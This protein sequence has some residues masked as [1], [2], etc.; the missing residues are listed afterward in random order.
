M[1]LTHLIPTPCFLGKKILLNWFTGLFGVHHKPCPSFQQNFATHVKTRWAFGV[2]LSSNYMFPSWSWLCLTERC[3]LAFGQSRQSSPFQ[4]AFT[5]KSRLWRVGWQLPV[6][7]INS[8]KQFFVH[9]SLKWPSPM[10]NGPDDVLSLSPC[11]DPVLNPVL[12]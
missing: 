1:T 7:N 9:W 3:L 10:T 11:V 12:I 4:N 2:T 8:S 5:V 6:Q